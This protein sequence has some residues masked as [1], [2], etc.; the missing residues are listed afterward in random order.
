MF[1]TTAERISF[2]IVKELKEEPLTI[3][4]HTYL[5]KWLEANPNNRVTYSQ[6][7]DSKILEAELDKYAEVDTEKAWRRLERELD[8]RKNEE[9]HAALVCFIAFTLIAGIIIYAIFK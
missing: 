7:W 2:I 6:I 4:E 3:E 5:Q 1:T 8:E 9:R